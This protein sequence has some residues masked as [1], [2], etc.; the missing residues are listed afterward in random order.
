MPRPATTPTTACASH[1]KT[2]SCHSVQ[3]HT[4]A[5]KTA[6]QLSDPF[7][8]RS[9]RQPGELNTLDYSS[10]TPG[11]TLHPSFCRTFSNPSSPPKTREPHGAPA[12][13]CR[14]SIRWLNV[15][16]SAYVSIQSWGREPRFRSSF[17]FTRRRGEQR[18]E[19]WNSEGHAWAMASWTDT[20]SDPREI[21]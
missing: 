8:R 9:F 14:W 18:G 2:G 16:A 11:L 4:G 7:L 20:F 19:G 13:G 6:R 15:K 17:R 1:R 5:R 3:V 10:V 12:L 21:S